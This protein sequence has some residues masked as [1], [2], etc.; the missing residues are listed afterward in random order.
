MNITIPYLVCCC[1]ILL[2]SDSF[3]LIA[4]ADVDQDLSLDARAEID[5]LI[6]AELPAEFQTTLHPSIPELPETRFSSL[7][8]QELERKERNEPM[9]GGIDLSRYEAPEAPEA[10][11]NKDRSEVLKEWDQTL[12]RAYTASSHMSGRHDNLALLEQNGKNAWLIGNA[13]L[14]EM[15]RKVEKELQ[16]TKDAT[17]ALHKERKTRQEIAKGELLGLED[18]W[19]RGVSGIINVEIAAENLRTEILEK[20]RQQAQS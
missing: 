2:S 3:V 10:D 17:E 11:P 16:D 12:R 9:T 4:I 8:E 19:R 18:A 14:E 5:K 6:A 15:L 1:M 20:R 7:I 13:H